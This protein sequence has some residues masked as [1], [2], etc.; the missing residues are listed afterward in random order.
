MDKLLIQDQY[1]ELAGLILEADKLIARLSKT[2]K[3]EEIK[4]KTL[5]KLAYAK[6][7]K[8]HVDHMIKKNTDLSLS[9]ANAAYEDLISRASDFIDTTRVLTKSPGLNLKI[10]KEGLAQQFANDLNIRKATVDINSQIKDLKRIKNALYLE[11][12]R[13]ERQ[14]NQVEIDEKFEEI[15]KT[16]NNL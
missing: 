12:K 11:M 1:E 15:K 7:L 13:L 9:R 4:D 14:K 2:S 16:I 5:D 3:K 10:T 6:G 8:S